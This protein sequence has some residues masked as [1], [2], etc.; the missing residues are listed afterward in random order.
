M[1][2]ILT[3][4]TNNNANFKQLDEAGVSQMGKDLYSLKQFG[5]TLQN[6]QNVTAKVHQATYRERPHRLA[7]A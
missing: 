1:I 6:A 7:I 2:E 5:K 3:A 4:N